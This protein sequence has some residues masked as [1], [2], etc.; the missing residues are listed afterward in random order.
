VGIEMRERKCITW[1]NDDSPMTKML[2]KGLG[3]K[4]CFYNVFFIYLLPKLS[5][6]LS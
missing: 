6:S 5:I 2:E 3:Y 4:L 1:S